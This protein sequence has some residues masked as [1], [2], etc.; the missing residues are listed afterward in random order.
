MIHL[1]THADRIDVPLG[2]EELFFAPG[3]ARVI[4]EEVIS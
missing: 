1:N 4:G 3:V 2:S